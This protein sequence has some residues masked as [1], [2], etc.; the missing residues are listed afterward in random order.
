LK[1][2]PTLPEEVVQNFLTPFEK[3][4]YYQLKKEEENRGSA[5][6]Q[7]EKPNTKPRRSY[8]KK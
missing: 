2:L 5:E 7:M 6:P 8:A 4:L 1:K 3:F